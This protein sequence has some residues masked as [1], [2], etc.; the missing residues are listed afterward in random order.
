MNSGLNDKKR[1]C[2]NIVDVLFVLILENI[3]AIHLD[4]NLQANRELQ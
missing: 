2:L 1:M 3:Q 4:E